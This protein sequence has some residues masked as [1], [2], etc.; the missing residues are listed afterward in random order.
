VSFDHQIYTM[1]NSFE[2]RDSGVSVGTI[3]QLSAGV[4]GVKGSV[5]GDSVSF[6][7]GGAVVNSN[8]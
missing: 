1:L 6:K 8:K 5:E 4:S 3:N 7:S 2:A